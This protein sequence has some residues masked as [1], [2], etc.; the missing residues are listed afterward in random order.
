MLRKLRSII[1]RIGGKAPQRNV[2]AVIR[3]GNDILLVRN[4]HGRGWWNL[5]GGMVER[6]ESDET[7]LRREIAEE[8]GILVPPTAVLGSFPSPYVGRHEDVTIL[9][10]AVPDRSY[11]PD[12]REISDVGWFPISS[13]PHD[14]S[15]VVDRA[16]SLIR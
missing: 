15:P 2:R 8:L 3:N 6:G 11:V 14:R 13:V 7:A 16:V 10:A 12:R 9:S 5:P 1:S 4:K